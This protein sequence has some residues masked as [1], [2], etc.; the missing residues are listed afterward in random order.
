[1]HLHVVVILW[2]RQ[3]SYAN[4]W[5]AWEVACGE[6]FQVDIEELKDIRRMAKGRGTMRAVHY[7]TKYIAKREELA[8]LEAGPGGLA[9]L[10]SGTRGMRTFAM[11][12]GCS[13]LRRMID[14]LM[15]SW[16]LQAER[17]MEDAELRDGRP[18]F[19]AEELD[20]TT[21]E[22]IETAIPKPYLDGA[23]RARWRALA[24]PL[25]FPSTRTVGQRAG[26]R[27]QFRRI[28][29]LPFQGQAITLAEHRRGD[30]Q[31]GIRALVAGGRWKV[32]HWE[33]VSRKTGKVLKFTVALP[34]GRYAWRSIADQVWRSM[35]L[36]QGGWAK[37]RRNAFRSHAEAAV[38]PL[39]KR[40]NMHSIH[41]ALDDRVTFTNGEETRTTTRRSLKAAEL[42]THYL[43][44]MASDPLAVWDDTTQAI[45]RRAM[46]LER[47][48]LL[49]VEGPIL[50][51]LRR[52]LESSF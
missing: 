11:G 4:V 42:W 18:P 29:T 14:V 35:G 8:K 6:R 7:I 36:D 22:V 38:D 45:R 39:A 31:R 32:Q 30:P 13:V 17:I 12:G 16:A 27:G 47:P 37:A 50:R 34:A 2:S 51:Q 15:P 3:I 25:W 46:D 52:D 43:V 19:R 26:P 20:P 23:E 44:K 1:M 10:F 33:E 48:C 24:E 9:H 41:A 49:E 40:D 21:G 28:G 5:D